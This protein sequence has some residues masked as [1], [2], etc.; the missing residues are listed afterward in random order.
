MATNYGDFQLEIYIGGL[1]GLRPPFPMTYEHLRRR[2]AEALAPEVLSYVAGG[3]GDEF[4]QDFNVTA[5]ERYGL[6]P[7]MLSGAAQRDLSIELFGV[8]YPTPLMLAPIG[9][10]GLC[11]QDGHGDIATAQAAARTGVPMV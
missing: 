5:F 4:T 2:A 9:V 7:R 1:N 3:A 6:I 10:I 8:S 11:A